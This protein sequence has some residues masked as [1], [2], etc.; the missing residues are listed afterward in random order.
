[1]TLSPREQL[2]EQ[3]TCSNYPTYIKEYAGNFTIHGLLH[4]LQ[5]FNLLCDNE[6]QHYNLPEYAEKMPQE[7]FDEIQTRVLYHRAEESSIKTSIIKRGGFISV[8]NGSR[9][10]GT[11]HV[12]GLQPDYIV[13]TSSK[14]IQAFIKAMSL[15]NTDKLSIE[16]KIDKVGEILRRDFILKTE[17]EDPIYLEL[18]KKYKD[19][20]LE[21]PLSEYLKIKRGVCREVS[22]LTSIALNSLGIES[23]Y[24]Y[25]KVRTSF[26]G[27]SKEEDHAIV[28]VSINGKFLISDNY[29]R[30]FNKEKLSNLETPE[31][32]SCLSGLMYDDASL[33]K[34]GEAHVFMSRLYP[35]TRHNSRHIK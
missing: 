3:L 16:E 8:A 23:Y 7:M 9:V 32:A 6:V 17:Y 25:A 21:V 10:Q 13:D 26:D 35:E 2:Y 31:G 34:K 33:S 22:M 4:Q 1:M 24:Y 30:M 11:T 14:E 28:P 27:L 15:L 20:E 19:A 5:G 18:L 12:N 29:F